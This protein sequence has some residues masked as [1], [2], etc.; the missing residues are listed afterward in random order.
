M[1]ILTRE[2]TKKMSRIQLITFD[3]DDTFWDIRSTIINAE[4]NSRKWT[5]DRIGKKQSGELL[6]ILWKLEVS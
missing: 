6:K 1:K 3:L 5:E 4:K 2:P